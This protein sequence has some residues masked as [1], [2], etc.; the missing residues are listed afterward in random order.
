AS[1]TSFNTMFRDAEAFN[2]DLSSW[3]FPNATN[4]SGMFRNTAFNQDISG[5][6]VSGI[7]DFSFM[8]WE[9][10]NFNQPLDSWDVS[11]ATSFNSMFANCLVFNQDLNS[12]NTSSVTNMRNVFGNSPAFNGNISNWDVSSVTNMSQMFYQTD[13]F[14]GDLSGWNTSS[15]TDMSFIFY[16]ASVFNSDISSWNTSSVT[17]MSGA[18]REMAVF[19]Q[20][21]SGWQVG[22]VTNMQNMFDSSPAFNHSLDTWDMSSVT[23]AGGML[24]NSGLSMVN[25]QTTLNGWAQ[26]SLQTG[27][28]FS[29]TN[30][31]YCDDTGRQAL[32][33]NFA[34]TINDGSQACP[35]IFIDDI[36]TDNVVSISEASNVEISGTSSLIED[37]GTITITLNS[38]DDY[39]AIVSADVWS[40]NV[41][42]TLLTEGEV[43]VD[44]TFTD[45]GGNVA[46]ANST[47]DLDLA[48]PVFTSATTASV[49]ENI[50][51]SAIVYTAVATDANAVT[52]SLSGTDASAFAI[53]GSTGDMTFVS[54]PDFETQ[55]SYEV[56]IT[57]TDVATNSTDLTLTITINDLDEDAPVF[58]SPNTASA[59][60]NIS[61]STIVY[62]AVATDANAVTYSLS[63]TDASAFAID[64]STGD[65]T[66]V[67]SPDFET[68]TSYEVVITATD[69]ATNST[70]LTL[71]ITINDLDEDAPTVVLS[72]LESDPTNSSPIVVNIA[73]SEVVTGFV[74]GDVTVGNGT[75]GNLIDLDGSN[76]TVEITSNTDGEVTVDVASGVAQDLAGNFNEAAIQFSITVDQLVP[77]VTINSLS[78]NVSSPELTGAVDDP[79]ATIEITVNGNT[80]PVTNSSGTWVL[81]A[82]TIAPDLT[83]GTY[84]I[85]ASAA[86]LAGNV[87]V[88]LTTDELVVDLTAP[89]VSVSILSTLN[90]SP[91]LTGSV[92]DAGAIIAVTV[93]G[94]DYSGSNNGDGSWTLPEGTINSLAV[95]VY[96]VVVTATDAVGNT[97][98]DATSDELII[99]PGAPTA[100]AASEVDYFSFVANW[101]ARAGVESYQVDV[102]SDVSFI[103]KLPG[104]NNLSLTETSVVVLDVDYGSHYYYRVRAVYPSEAV[105]PSSNV[106]MVTTPT[107]ANTI[108]DSTALLEIYDALG[109]DNWQDNNWSDEP[110]LKD[111]SG[112]KMTGTRVSELDLSSTGLTGDFPTIST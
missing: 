77:V 45:L 11:S 97:G 6:D 61:T 31:S 70:D 89:T 107:D 16:R 95:G 48:A 101:K 109:G 18:F 19:N 92:D 30:L 93:D 88:D 26:Q 4:M 75:A 46:F 40:T 83:E 87:G 10:N 3:V 20:D 13:A 104:Y 35:E 102:A 81:A 63:G 24:A 22:Q 15:V 12:W 68:Q 38:T 86:D 69:V 47:V 90:D 28:S 58:T 59:D 108:A 52:Y 32:I 53:D 79:A 37:G 60:E 103:N 73:F 51:T 21:I 78:T 112:V 105:S 5:W 66:F 99:E 43:T 36:S 50:S 33:D 14:T 62:T 27:V 29:A 85:T 72:T 56:V 106:I 65:M 111:W 71:T 44:V 49:D 25:Y 9:A 23:A 91:A 80:Y 2:Q 57:A 55:T 76:Y 7:Q 67:S 39:S 34:W 1:A 8:F 42:M 94:S 82:G 41:D 54:S 96:D 98:T 64:G 100:L 74:V 17:N 110:K 84:D